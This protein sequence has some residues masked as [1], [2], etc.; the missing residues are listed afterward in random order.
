MCGLCVRKCPQLS[1]VRQ[2]NPSPVCYAVMADEK[3]RMK[4][5]SGGMFTIAASWILE[6]GGVVCGAAFDDDFRVRH[7]MI[8]SIDKLPALRGSKYIQS[9]MDNIYI[10]IK[11]KLSEG[12]P[13]LFTGVPCQVAALY[14][15]VGRN[16]KNLYTIDLVCHGVSSYK[17]LEKYLHDVHHEKLVKELYFKRK[18]SCGWGAG[19]SI[20]FEDGTKYEQYH[21]FDPFLSPITNVTA[22]MP[23]VHFVNQI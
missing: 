9:S 1:P 23:P 10:Q 21:Y 8:H 16:N 6:Q 11:E 3:T 2:N 5:S 17:V 19:T 14:S 22:K 7:V 18:E 20:F 13:V 15:V 4:S 12:T